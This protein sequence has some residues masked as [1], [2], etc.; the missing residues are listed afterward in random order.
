MTFSAIVVDFDTQVDAVTFREEEGDIY[1]RTLQHCN[2]QFLNGLFPTL[3]TLPP[4]CCSL[5]NQ[6]RMVNQHL[7]TSL[8]PRQ[9]WTGQ[10]E[11]S[12]RSSSSDNR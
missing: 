9:A 6:Q 3:P 8:P 2:S 7:H 12:K 4:C 11:W 10:P 1:K 5:L